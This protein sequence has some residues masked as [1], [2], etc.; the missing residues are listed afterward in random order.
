MTAFRIDAAPLAIP[1]DLTAA[2]FMLDHTHPL[3]PPRPATAPWF[4]DDTT[5]R[6]V[7]LE[8]VQ[9]RL[10]SRSLAALTCAKLRARVWGLANAMAADY[11]LGA[12]CRARLVSS[13]L[14]MRMH[15]KR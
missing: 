14:T 6:P 2:Q 8:E 11:G 1:D 9:F 15:R 13:S 7:F 3:R 5:G 4:I 10:C 12:L